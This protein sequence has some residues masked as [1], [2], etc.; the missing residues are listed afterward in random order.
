MFLHSACPQMSSP[1][2]AV[3]VCTLGSIWRTSK[4][5][6][7]LHSPESSTPTFL[8]G[9]QWVRVL[10]LPTCQAC[11]AG[12]HTQLSAL[13]QWLACAAAGPALA[14]QPPA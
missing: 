4:Q 11:C 10:F 13:T 7:L 8:A 5:L 2:A 1:D 9:H 6:Y 12:P 3:E 14:E